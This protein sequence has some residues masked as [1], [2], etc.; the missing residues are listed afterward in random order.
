MGEFIEDVFLNEEDAQKGK[1]LLFLVASE[2]YGVEISDVLEIIGM[3]PITAVPN[4]PAYAKGIINVRGKVVPVIDMRL[5]F[6]KETKEYD[7]KTSII[8]VSMNEMTVGLIVDSVQ[9]LMTIGD[10]N[11]VMPPDFKTGFQNRFINRIGLVDN[12][13]LLLI[14]CGKLIKEDE[15][16]QIGN[17]K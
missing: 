6:E 5:K 11:I 1:F 15:I 2:T 17:M 3:Q 8:V 9:E 7:Q 10:E 4:A 16:E 14:D 12:R 13:V